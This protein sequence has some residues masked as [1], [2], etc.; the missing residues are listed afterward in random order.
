MKNSVDPDQSKKPANLDLH[1]FWK[2][3][4]NDS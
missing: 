2:Q 3:D 4:F 1:C